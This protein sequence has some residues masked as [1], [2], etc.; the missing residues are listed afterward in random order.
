MN[1]ELQTLLERRVREWA[2]L[3][4]RLQR[5]PSDEAAERFWY[6]RTKAERA[7]EARRAVDRMRAIHAS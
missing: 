5:E 4:D 3:A 6:G 2:A 7:A 1:S